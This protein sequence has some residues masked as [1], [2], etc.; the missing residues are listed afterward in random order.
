MATQLINLSN[1]LELHKRAKDTDALSQDIATFNEAFK[2]LDHAVET[3][4][5]RATAFTLSSRNILDLADE[6]E[7]WL[8]RHDMPKKSR[9][10]VRVFHRPAGPS[11]KSYKFRATTTEVV[12]VRRTSG[13]FLSEIKRGSVNPKQGATTRYIIN[14]ATR[15]VIVRNALAGTEIKAAA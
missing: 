3:V 5:G 1:I 7:K 8:D 14:E 6:A 10:G 13:W 11:A 12:I 9:V 2:Q 4:N 15:D